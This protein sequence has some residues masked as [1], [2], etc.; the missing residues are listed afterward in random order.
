MCEQHPLKQGILF[1]F[2]CDSEPFCLDCLNEGFHK[3]HDVI[4]IEGNFHKLAGKM[5]ETAHEIRASVEI[6]KA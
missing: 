1:C 6:L 2:E 5:K 4:L 3:S